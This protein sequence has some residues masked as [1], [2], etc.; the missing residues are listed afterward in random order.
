[1]L[2]ASYVMSDWVSISYGEVELATYINIV[3]AML[4]FFYLPATHMVLRGP[5]EGPTPAWLERRMAG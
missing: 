5:N 4:A 1:M 2:V 3:A